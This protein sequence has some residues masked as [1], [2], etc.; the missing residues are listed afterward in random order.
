ML[1][2]LPNRH[3]MRTE[4]IFENQDYQGFIG[5]ACSDPNPVFIQSLSWPEH[6]LLN[7]ELRQETFETEY[8]QIVDCQALV[9][10]DDDTETPKTTVAEAGTPASEPPAA[11]PARD[12]R[13]VRA[14]K[15]Q[16]APDAAL[17][18][19]RKKIG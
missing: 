6:M 11:R 9:D 12:P 18:S 15:A 17:N 14:P 3:I 19:P 13:T 2:Q 8:Q 5:S 1:E 10:P 4:V 16:D 7:M